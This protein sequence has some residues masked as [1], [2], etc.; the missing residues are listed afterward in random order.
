MCFTSCLGFGFG[1]ESGFRI[2]CVDVAVGGILAVS[3]TVKSMSRWV[4]HE[5][6][7]SMGGALLRM[8]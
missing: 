4:D 3:V 5:H 8:I 6:T 7:F 1:F 2:G